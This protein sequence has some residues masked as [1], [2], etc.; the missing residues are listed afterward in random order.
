MKLLLAKNQSKGLMGGVSFE[1]KARVELTQE[2]QELVKHYKL[3]NEVLLSKK[4]V[5]F[6]GQPLD[7]TVQVS[8]KNLLNGENYKCKDLGE[9]IAYSDSLKSACK[10]LW[11]YLNVARSFGGQEVI[12]IPGDEDEQEGHSLK[13]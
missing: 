3:E 1:V 4:M 13:D 11:V 8:V 9:V 7:Q 2:E 5:G 10:T 6:W 12:E